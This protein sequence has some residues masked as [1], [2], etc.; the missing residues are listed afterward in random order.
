LLGRSVPALS[1]RLLGSKVSTR[2][3]ANLLRLKPGI[4]TAALDQFG[5]QRRRWT[6]AP[7]PAGNR[8]WP[9]LRLNAL[10]ITQAPTVCRRIMC[11]IGGYAEIRQAVEASKAD[12]LVARTSAGVLGFGADS[13]MRAAFDLYQIT[14][15]DLHTIEARRLRNDS[16]ERGLLREALTRAIARHRGLKFIRRGR[17]DLLVPSDPRSPDWKEL[18]G[19]VSGL[20]GTVKGYPELRWH[21]GVGTRLDWANEQL[22]LLIEPRTIFEGITDDNRA[23]ATDFARERTVK[24]YNRQ[25]NGLIAF[26]AHHLAG[27][28]SDL[29]AFG[30]GD[31]VDAVFRLGRETAYSRRAG[32]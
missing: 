3:S 19:Q 8:A 17:S 21:E 10:P 23:A 15:F 24:R 14:V 12:V 1:R 30:T 28:G 7:A 25:L 18:S 5:D 31:G 20:T 16:G 32:A 6:P 29:R 27:D 26:W 13:S 2:S 4:D 22:W 11:T 9:V